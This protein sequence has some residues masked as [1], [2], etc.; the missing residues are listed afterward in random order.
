MYKHRLSGTRPG[1]YPTG[2]PTGL[3]KLRYEYRAEP[4]TA[5]SQKMAS[6]SPPA[7]AGEMGRGTR[8]RGGNP[9]RT[10]QLKPVTDDRETYNDSESVSKPASDLPREPPPRFELGTPSLPWRCS[11]TELRRHVFSCLRRFRLLRV[12]LHQTVRWNPG[13][14]V[15]RCAGRRI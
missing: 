2:A 11:T 6:S 1:V 10:T 9:S 15:S 3:R 5:H 12:P 8:A 7:F 14:A 4:P 13:Y